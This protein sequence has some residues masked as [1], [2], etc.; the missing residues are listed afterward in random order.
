MLGHRVSL[1]ALQAGGF[2]LKD[3]PPADIVTKAG[4]STAD[5]TAK[6]RRILIA[7]KYQ[8]SRPRL[9]LDIFSRITQIPS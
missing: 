2:L 3:S 9:I 7:T 6:L 8:P 4:S 5:M 1:M